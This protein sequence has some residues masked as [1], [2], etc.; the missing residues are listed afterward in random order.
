M[1]NKRPSL[2]K[3]LGWKG[4]EHR[5]EYNSY[6]H[7]H[8]NEKFSFFQIFAYHLIRHWISYNLIVIIILL[9]NY[10]HY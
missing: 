9:K 10:K 1:Q 8:Y 3:E 4:I 7:I 2:P 6:L 5:Q